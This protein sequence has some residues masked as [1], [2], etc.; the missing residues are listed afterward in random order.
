MRV[1]FDPPKGP[2][3][4]NKEDPMSGGSLTKEERK[5]YLDLCNKLITDPECWNKKTVDKILKITKKEVLHKVDDLFSH[6]NN[7]DKEEFRGYIEHIFNSAEKVTDNNF[8][9]KINI[10]CYQCIILFT[11]HALKGLSEENQKKEFTNVAVCDKLYD[12]YNEMCRLFNNEEGSWTWTYTDVLN[13]VKE[14]SN[15]DD[16]KLSDL[17]YAID[18]TA[19]YGNNREYSSNRKKDEFTYLIIALDYLTL[20]EINESLLNRI[21]YCGLVSK[22]AYADNVNLLPIQFVC[23]DIEHGY[24]MSGYCVSK[25]KEGIGHLN[26]IKDF[27]NYCKNNIMDKVELYHIQFAIFYIVHEIDGLDACNFN[28][29]SDVDKFVISFLTPTVLVKDPMQRFMDYRTD[30]GSSIPEEYGGSEEEIKRFLKDVGTTYIKYMNQWAL[31]TKTGGYR[32][33]R[34]YKKRKNKRSSRKR[35]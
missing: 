27:Y 3:K 31:E 26:K 32:A 4:Y 8:I 15:R 35:F 19:H 2:H 18:D 22:K 5:E 29:Y 7:K 11:Y 24:T 33:R 23:H 34:T 1:K 20:D 16:T 10:V 12:V 13:Y 6:K 25:Q 30:L 14:E 17:Y 21:V 28:K 9:G